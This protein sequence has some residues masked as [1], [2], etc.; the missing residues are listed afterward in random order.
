MTGA[1]LNAI[2]WKI[3][4]AVFGRTLSYEQTAKLCG[5]RSPDSNGG[6]KIRKWEMDEAGP[7]G[8]VAALLETFAQVADENA[9]QQFRDALAVQIRK[10][11]LAP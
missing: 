11:I 5:L 10:R 1:E 2:R 7:T 9:S 4:H 3:G 6:D 8:P